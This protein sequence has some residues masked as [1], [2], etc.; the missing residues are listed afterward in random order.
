RPPAVLPRRAGRGPRP[1][2]PRVREDVPPKAP[3]VLRGGGRVNA[4]Y[5]SPVSFAP[6]GLGLATAIAGA[7]GA[8]SVAPPAGAAPATARPCSTTGLV[9]A[10]SAH[11]RIVA[12]RVTGLTCARARG[13]AR[14]IAGD[15]IAGKPV[16]LSGVTSYSESQSQC[17]G[18]ASTTQIVLAYPRGKLTIS[19]S[20]GGGGSVSTGP[21]GGGGQVF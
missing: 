1:P 8:A 12:L 21:F 2:H 20:D 17:T 16:S 6:M 3:I 9:P 19:I 4:A 13:I 11:G 7:A 14:T 18:C 10:H 5:P 15:V